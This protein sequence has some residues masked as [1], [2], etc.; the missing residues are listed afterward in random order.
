M[1]AILLSG[2][3]ASDFNEEPL[4]LTRA[5]GGATLMDTQIQ[6]LIQ[7]GLEVIC[8]VSGQDAEQQ[9]RVCPRIAD[10]DLVF[11][12]NDQV[13]L[14]SN[15]K[16]GLAATGEEGCFALPVEITPPPAE[17]WRFLKHEWARL[18][19]AFEAPVLQAVDAQGAPWHFGFPLL[20]TKTGNKMI[21][22]LTSFHSLTD[23]RLNYHHLPY[24]A[25]SILAP[26]SKAA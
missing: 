22:G 9:L 15:L 26:Q 1:K 2:Y 19:F 4:G 8:V 6:Q 11:D 10:T 17:V 3:R 12:T 25:E 21:R 7:L 14:A 18:G 13:S 16:S 20:I 24:Q 23:S 5:Q